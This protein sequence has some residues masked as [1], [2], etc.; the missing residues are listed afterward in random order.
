[1]AWL[2]EI[3]VEGFWD[4]AVHAAHRKWGLLG[5]ALALLSPFLFFGLLIWCAVHR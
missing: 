4:G 2:V 5:G 3:I 1:M